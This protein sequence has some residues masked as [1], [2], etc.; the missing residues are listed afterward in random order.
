MRWNCAHTLENAD[1]SR[2][3]VD[4]AGGLQGRSENLDGGDEIVGE[5][6][7]Q[8]ALSSGRVSGCDH[9]RGLKSQLIDGRASSETCI[10]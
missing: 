6:V 4:T 9:G 3:V 7:V 5:A 1:G 8:V 10:A 2:E